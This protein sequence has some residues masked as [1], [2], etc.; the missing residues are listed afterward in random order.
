MQV[1]VILGLEWMKISMERWKY[2]LL[3]W[4]KRTSLLLARY[5]FSFVL[6]SKVSLHLET[7][8]YMIVHRKCERNHIQYSVFIDTLGALLLNDSK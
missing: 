7:A 5:I 6:F 8:V 2:D 3:I 1:M 4:K